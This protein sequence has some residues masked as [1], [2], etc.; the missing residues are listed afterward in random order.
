ME[1]HLGFIL[2]YQTMQNQTD[3]QVAVTI[4][5]ESKKMFPNLSSCSF[6]KG[7]HSPSNQIKLKEILDTVALP[8]KGKLLKK[9][10]EH[11]Q[12]KT[13][14][15]AKRKHSA[16]ESA[17]NALEVH[18]LDRCPDKGIDGFERYI[19]L[20]ILGRNLQIIG[21]ILIKRDQKKQRKDLEKQKLAA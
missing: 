18:G 7:F 11:Q 15:V 3:D 12:S 14:K 4:V 1:D 6:D 19:G 17:I 20:A 8:K 2:N 21:S 9:D 10:V 5:Q 16:V 13:Y